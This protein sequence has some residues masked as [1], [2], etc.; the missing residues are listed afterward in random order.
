ME[1]WYDKMS[2]KKKLDAQYQFKFAD[3]Y[4]QLQ[5][6]HNLNDILTTYCDLSEIEIFSE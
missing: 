6:F 1:K 4:F 3:R 5:K 2:N